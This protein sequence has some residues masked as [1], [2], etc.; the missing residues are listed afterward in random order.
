MSGPVDSG[1]PP[2]RDGGPEF[3]ELFKLAKDT[4][5]HAIRM[6]GQHLPRAGHNRVTHEPTIRDGPDR[7]ASITEGQHLMT[8]NLP[9]A[10]RRAGWPSCGSLR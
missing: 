5:V 3:D 9:T 6:L 4:H 10:T 8:D 1:R 7:G 2:R